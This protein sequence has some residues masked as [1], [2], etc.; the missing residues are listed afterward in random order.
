MH[1]LENVIFKNHALHYLCHHSEVENVPLRQFVEEFETCHVGKNND[2]VLRFQPD[3][4]YYSHPSVLKAG[5][6]CG[7]CS[8]GVRERAD[9]NVL[10]C[11]SQQW[12]FLDTASFKHNIFTCLPSQMKTAMEDYAQLVLTLF[13]PH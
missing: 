12:M 6:N 4:G 9:G 7:K 5:K 8:Q 11:V 2:D 3:T 13:L 1:Q 10:I